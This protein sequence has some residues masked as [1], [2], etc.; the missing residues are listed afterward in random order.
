MHNERG[1][2]TWAG[3]VHLHNSRIQIVLSLSVSAYLPHHTICLNPALLRRLFIIYLRSYFSR[4][5]VTH[6]VPLKWR[7]FLISLT[8]SFIYRSHLLS[9]YLSLLSVSE[10]NTNVS[11]C[12]QYLSQNSEGGGENIVR[13]FSSFKNKLLGSSQLALT[14]LL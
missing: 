14:L 13:P 9:L 1:Q 6:F 7:I 3:K 10:S 2:S 5:M 8:A 4:S 11:P 12:C